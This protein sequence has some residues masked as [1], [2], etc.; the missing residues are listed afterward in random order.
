MP[1]K[2]QAIADELRIHIEAGKYA[3]SEL[4]PTEF[5]IAEEYRVSRQTVR[6]ALS[7]LVKDGLIEKRQ[8]S[9][10]RIVRHSVERTGAQ[11]CSVAV[12]TTYISDYIFPSI[13]REVEKTLAEHNCTP[14]CSAPRTR[15]TA[16]GRY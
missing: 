8:G 16:R 7:V 4:L 3:D 2:Y 6:Q 12:I 5:A 1:P 10:S 15:S 13:L 14:P 11:P 9:G